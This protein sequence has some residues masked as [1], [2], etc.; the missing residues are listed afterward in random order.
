MGRPR[1]GVPS[2]ALVVMGR[3]ELTLMVSPGFCETICLRINETVE[4][5]IRGAWLAARVGSRW[6]TEGRAK[7]PAR[8]SLRR[9]MG[10]HAQ[11]TSL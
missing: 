8:R 4:P 7:V 10:I 5:D 11:V 6:S 1:R 3:F 2:S 9:R